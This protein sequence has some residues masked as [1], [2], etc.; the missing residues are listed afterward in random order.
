[1]SQ[2]ENEVVM[3]IKAIKAFS[4]NY[5]WALIGD[6]NRLTLVDPGDAAV[7][8]DFINQQNMTLDSILITH[9]HPD[10]TGG[11]IKLT[12]HAAQLGNTL[13]V[14]G[15]VNESING[16]TDKL[17]E[18][19]TIYLAHLDRE[20]AIV[21]LPGHTLDHIAYVTEEVLFCGDTLFS[22]GC[23]RLLRVLHPKCW[24]LYIN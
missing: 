1:M 24:R 3:K 14:F 19:N 21:E 10:H 7:C 20:F 22:A 16:V 23:G 11:I 9:H 13:K 6:H 12:E 17:Q 15:P 8:I 18:N 5:I 4:D 2:D